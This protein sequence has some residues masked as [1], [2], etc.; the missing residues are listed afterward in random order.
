MFSGNEIVGGKLP[1]FTILEGEALRALSGLPSKVARTCITSPPYWRMRD[2]RHADQLG[3]E[4][5]AEQYIDKLITIL[6]EVYRVLAD[7]GTLWLNVADVYQ[8]KQLVGIPWTLALELKKRG[9]WWRAV[10]VWDK[11]SKP[12]SVKDRPTRAHEPIL[13][14]AKSSEYYYD[15]EA[16]LEPHQS[17]WALDCI[18]KAQKSGAT[19]RR[20]KI[21]SK[22]QRRAEPGITRA[23]FGVLMNPKGRNRRDVWRITGAKHRGFHSAVMP[24]ALAEL[25]IRAG[26]QE[27]D[28]VL[29]PFCGTGTSGLAALKLGRK[30]IGIDLLKRF[31]VEARQR[32]SEELS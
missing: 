29:D 28:L 21:F 22:D 32:L 6:M 13:L 17:A 30:F 23:D 20:E 4:R 5:T 9:W 27:G 26:S 2:Y 10:I 12:E 1:R 18:R 7:D 24:Q 19:A 15:F 16:L 14:F 8:N 25:C 11:A 3:R 31:A